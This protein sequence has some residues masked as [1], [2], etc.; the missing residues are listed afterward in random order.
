MAVSDIPCKRPLKSE[1]L[2]QVLF[3]TEVTFCRLSPLFVLS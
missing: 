2:K 3:G 1:T